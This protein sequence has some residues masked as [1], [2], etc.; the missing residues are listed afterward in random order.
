[1][2]IGYPDPKDTA[3][4]L[5][6]QVAY[7]MFRCMQGAATQKEEASYIEL[8]TALRPFAPPLEEFGWSPSSDMPCRDVCIHT[9]A[10]LSSYLCA[11]HGI[12]QTNEHKYPDLRN[13]H[14]LKL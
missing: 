5:E 14:N 3:K 6:N 4:D 2:E 7:H 9:S 10:V 11:L 8:P 1:M 12:T 13:G